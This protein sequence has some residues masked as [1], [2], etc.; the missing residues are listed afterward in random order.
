MSDYGYGLWVLVA[1]DSLLV[2]F[3]AVSFFHPAGRRDWRA[4]GGFAA[5]IV[6]LFSEMYG[7]PLTIYLLS[8]MLGSKLG[9]GHSSGHLWNDLIGWQGDPHL[10]PFHIASY[11]LIIAGF[12]LIAAAW[13]VLL[14]AQKAGELATAGPYTRVRHPQ[15][16]GL[17]LIMLG[18]LVQWPTIPTLV[19]FPAL[20]LAYRRLA[21]REEREVQAQFGA[22]WEQYAQRTPRFVPARKGRR[23]G[24]EPDVQAGHRS[25][26]R[27]DSFTAS[28]SRPAILTLKRREQP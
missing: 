25:P 20:A 16:S 23:R 2:I 10:S 4:L 18:F 11:V 19:M 27:R 1:F 28:S 5:F 17:L 3:F 8:G 7:Y 6:A 21:T 26:N 22:A 12:W 15:Y 24:S 13:R 9:L 14:A